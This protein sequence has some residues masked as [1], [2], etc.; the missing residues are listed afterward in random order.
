MNDLTSW[1]PRPFPP[2]KVLE[3]QHC[4]LEP[5][6]VA[7][8]GA[9]IAAAFAGA[10]S[11]WDYLPVDEPKDRTAYEAFLASMVSRTDIVP[12]AVVDEADGKAKGHLWL[13]EI[14]PAHG[15]FEVGFITY[16]P[17]LQR[18][19]A[20]TEAIYLCGAYGF[21]LGYRRF[22]WKCN[23]RNEPSKR[24]AQRYG[25]KYEG[26][27]RQHQV[28]KG[29][30]R[31]TAWFSILD[32]EWPARKAAFQRWLDPVNFD[33]DGRQKTSLAALNAAP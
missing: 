17:G 19:R 4:R 1:T 28:V 11:V 9:D 15:V 3:G 29:Q 18:T 23:N 7:K 10:H 8:H 26:L 27:F 5:L 12:F 33:K 6:D 31:D 25:F 21:E 20:A 2:R 24:A 13:M 16:S 22:E 14:R 32:T 30:N